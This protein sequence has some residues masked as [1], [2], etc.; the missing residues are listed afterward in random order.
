[1]SS[2]KDEEEEEEKK[3]EPKDKQNTEVAFLVH[4]L[5]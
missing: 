1:M 3:T 4:Y 2:R 5:I